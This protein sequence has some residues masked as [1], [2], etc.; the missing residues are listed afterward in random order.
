MKQDTTTSRAPSL[1]IL[2][3]RITVISKDIQSLLLT[4][5]RTAFSNPKLETS[6]NSL[7]FW[8][9]T[10]AESSW[11][12]HSFLRSNRDHLTSLAPSP[13]GLVP[14]TAVPVS[15]TWYGR[16]THQSKTSHLA[17]ITERPENLHSEMGTLCN[18]ITVQPGDLMIL[19]GDSC[20]GLFWK[21]YWHV[22]EGV[23]EPLC[24]VNRK[25][26]RYSLALNKATC[27]L[28]HIKKKTLIGT[29]LQMRINSQPTNGARTAAVETSRVSKS[30][31]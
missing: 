18:C 19:I 24:R 7:E 23:D 27:V 31:R 10:K 4:L 17:E 21:E 8:T 14:S 13:L 5:P 26:L 11:R 25:D 1:M 30:A 12:P 28:L 22:L 29:A 2:Y 16:T 15:G 3:R 9:I 20:R 6:Q